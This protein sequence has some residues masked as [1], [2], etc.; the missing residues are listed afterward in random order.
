MEE[1]GFF[2]GFVAGFLAAGVLG[3]LLQKIRLAQKRAG[4]YRRPQKVVLETDMTP[5]EVVRDSAAGGL[6]CAVWVLILI[7]VMAAVLFLTFRPR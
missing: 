5:L 7:A 1:M 6:S 3:F 2:E 4:A